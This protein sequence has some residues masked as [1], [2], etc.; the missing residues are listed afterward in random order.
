MQSWFRSSALV[1]AWLV[2]GFAVSGF[3][4]APNSN[5]TYQQLR[6]L[7]PSG[8]AVS[9]QDFK[10]DRDAAVFTF[11]SGSFAFYGAV[12]GKVTGAVFRGNGSLHLVPPT[13]QEKRSLSLLTREPALD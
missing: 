4:Q 9:V 1:V 11:H 3:G 2:G 8:D 7:V 10:L 6:H 5:S 12:N 13:E